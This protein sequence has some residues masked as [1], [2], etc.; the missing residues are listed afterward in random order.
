[1]KK[2]IVA[3][4]NK[5]KLREIEEILSGMNLEVVSMEQVGIDEDIEEYGSTF[6]ENALIKAREVHKITGELVMADDSGLEVDAL[7]GAPGIYSSRF[8]GEGASDADRNNKLLEL[9][10]DVP[11]ENRK[12]RFVCAIAVILPDGNHFTVRGTFEGF[13]GIEPVGANGFGYDPLF[14][15][16]EY[17]KTAAQL[18]AAKKHEISHRGKALNLMLAE[19]RERL[20]Q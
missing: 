4:K 19:L 7:S 12:A 3:T 10:K 16:P 1:M 15:L 17:N 18:E 13:I 8:A 20:I 9:L 6:E 2:F 11:F 14:F 5:G